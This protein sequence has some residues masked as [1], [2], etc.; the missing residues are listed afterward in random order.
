MTVNRSKKTAKVKEPFIH[1][2]GEVLIELPSLSWVMPAIVRKIRHLNLL[3]QQFTLMEM[4]LD[5]EQLRAIDTLDPDE[6]EEMCNEWKRHSGID[7]G[8]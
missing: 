2:I 5:A 3:D 1:Q 8:E 4:H 7:L 6:F